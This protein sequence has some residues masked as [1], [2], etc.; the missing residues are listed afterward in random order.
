MLSPS[1]KTC[2]ITA[3]FPAHVR[4][5]KTLA[6]LKALHACDPRPEEILIHV[7]GGTEA[8]VSA[9]RE[10]WPDVRILQ[11]ETL[12]G[13]GGAR[14][15]LIHEASHELVANFDDDSFP[16]S[17]DYFARVL[18]T[19]E[20]FPDAAAFSAAS[21]ESEWSVPDFLTISCPSGCGCVIRKSWFER[22]RGFVPL[23][24]AF[25]ME[26][27]DVGLQWH[28]IGGLVVQDP[29]LRVTHDHP[30]EDRTG[31]NVPATILANTALL[32]L[33]RYPVWLWPIAVWHVLSQIRYYLGHGC[34]AA[35]L[36]GLRMIPSHARK[37]W[38]HRQ[39][40]PA[41]AVWSWLKLRRHPQSLGKAQ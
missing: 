9:V 34:R 10:A 20:R 16:S 41:A 18:E 33:L 25:N 12:L 28:A 1:P 30:E 38:R 22:T 14:N 31:C 3:I 23:V 4:V 36:P 8:V 19:A 39:A 24:I 5:E 35:I 26:E 17:P 37:H 7:D 29:K 11:S 40:V 27:V 2:P 15:R 32:P 13:P 6:T 21:Q